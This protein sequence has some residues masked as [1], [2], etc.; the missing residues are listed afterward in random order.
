MATVIRPA[1]RLAA[2][3]PSVPRKAVIAATAAFAGALLVA[4]AEGVKPF[5]YDAGNYW[6]IGGTF[7]RHG[8]FS[9]FNY[10]NTLRGYLLPLIDNRLL[11]VAIALDWRASALANIFNAACFAAI[12]AVLAPR[13]AE[14]AWGRRWGV[15]RRLALTGL[16]LLFWHGF[17]SYPL[18]DFPA[19]TFM[20]IAVVACSRPESVGSMALAGLG[21]GAAI[22]ARPA[23]LPLLVLVPLLAVLMARERPVGERVSRGRRLVAWVVLIVAFA[24]VSLPQALISHRHFASWSFIPGSAAGLES[25]QLT[26]GMRLQRYDTFVGVGQPPQML[27]EDPAGTRLLAAQPGGRVAG[28][29]QYLEIVADHPGTML[30]LLVRHVVN[31]LDQRYP[32]P[33][34]ERVDTGPNRSL[35]LA[36]LLLLLLA[37]ARV[38]WP[39][40]RRALGRTRWRYPLTLL[41]CCVTAVPSAM[42]TRF[43]LPV[44][45]L[46][47]VVVLTPSGSWSRETAPRWR[48]F[49]A[50][51]LALA[52]CATVAT[53]VLLVASDASSHL[54]FA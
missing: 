10:S 11:R 28:L 1:R 42:E 45:T 18:S 36:G 50:R 21:A 24:A 15:A 4:L 54:R 9:L 13:L 8:D 39:P 41:A 7:F 5:Y 6:T 2:L 22:D 44:F 53:I 38:C 19:F 34:V 26:E 31:G 43:L 25:L 46:V 27:Y 51:A 20:L 52:A 47:Y 16:L 40:A 48:R 3:R 35:R 29:G 37:L 17:L 32:T 49:A 30:P 14:L 23:Y 33:Y 12:G